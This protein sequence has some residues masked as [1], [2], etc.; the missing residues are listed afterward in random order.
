MASA[1]PFI[2]HLR[3]SIIAT[4]V[5]GGTLGIVYPLL[6]YGIAQVCYPAKANGSLVTR[7]GKVVGS[8]LIGQ[9]FADPRY[10]H[11]RPSAA[12]NGYDPT[13]SGGSNFGPLSLKL[14]KGS[15]KL[16]PP[17][18][19]PAS[20]PAGAAA[21]PA[22][23]ATLAPAATDAAPAAAPD[24]I[25]DVDGI[26]L[27]VL[28]Y[29]DDNNIPFEAQR[30]GNPITRET[31]SNKDG[32]DDVKLIQAFND[33]DHPLTI[34]AVNPVPV[35]AVTASGSGLDPHISWSNA[36]YQVGRVAMERK[37]DQRLV[38]TLVLLSTTGRDLGFLGEP[39]VNVLTLNLALDALK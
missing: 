4:I 36:M 19:P 14:I 35:D 10:F 29:C 26:T 27:R 22:A 34:R 2:I 23:A 33:K 15:T 11:P 32:W 31:Y 6:V 28:H 12:G 9:N 18:T 5:L 21:A 37:I 20:P 16:P 1:T 39:V 30:D 17:P 3:T 24:P 25:V 8:L 38:M 7:G 13:S